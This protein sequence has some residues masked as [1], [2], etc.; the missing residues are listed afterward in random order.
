MK[1]KRTVNNLAKLVRHT[2]GG[3]QT[4]K[5]R[6]TERKNILCSEETSYWAIAFGLA[7]SKCRELGISEAKVDIGKD[8][9]GEQE[10]KRRATRAFRTCRYC[11]VQRKK[12]ETKMERVRKK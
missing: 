2:K 5:P 1:G 9:K 11:K 6:H 10:G 4:S 12:K 3:S 8:P 7:C